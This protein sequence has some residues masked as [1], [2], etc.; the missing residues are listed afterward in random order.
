MCAYNFIARRFTISGSRINVETNTNTLLSVP[1]FP[2]VPTTPICLVVI[3]RAEETDRFGIN[4]LRD[5]Y[6][7]YVFPFFL[8]NSSN[9][10]DRDALSAL[11]RHLP[12]VL[13]LA[14]CPT[15]FT[16]SH[17]CSSSSSSFYALEKKRKEKR[18]KG[19]IDLQVGRFVARF[20]IERI[21]S[22]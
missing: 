21:D 10:I 17:C 6:F 19:T 4:S 9:E 1:G 7:R 3:Y 8:A 5:E 15:E 13:Q 22:M 14:R 20:Q 11:E 18:R 12:T 16:H 2:I